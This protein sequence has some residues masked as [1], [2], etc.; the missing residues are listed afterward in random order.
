MNVKI[1]FMFYWCR[2][3][4]VLVVI[5]K[6][7]NGN[8]LLDLQAP[9]LWLALL[10]A[11]NIWYEILELIRSGR[12][13]ESVKWN[14]MI[15]EIWILNWRREGKGREGTTVSKFPLHLLP[16]LNLKMLF[17][18]LLSQNQFLDF[19]FSIAFGF[20]DFNESILYAYIHTYIHTAVSPQPLVFYHFSFSF[21]FIYCYYLYISKLKLKQKQSIHTLNL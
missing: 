16:F 6:N 7:K 17:F 19:H 9:R 21:V 10:M 12:C 13:K 20:L 2:C 4:K 8:V 3:I 11:Q 18:G 14:I 5:W 15:I 1:G